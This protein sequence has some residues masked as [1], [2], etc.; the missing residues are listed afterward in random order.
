MAPIKGFNNLFT[1]D[2]RQRLASGTVAEQAA[3]QRLESVVSSASLGNGTTEF[4]DN[5]DTGEFYAMMPAPPETDSVAF[6]HYATDE[7][8]AATVNV[9]D[10]LAPAG[11]A[12]LETSLQT[13]TGE[14]FA[15][16]EAIATAL[17]TETLSAHRAAA[18]SRLAAADGIV[19][20]LQDRS[21]SPDAPL[22]DGV[23]E[24]DGAEPRVQ[25]MVPT[26]DGPGVY[27]DAPIS[28]FVTDEGLE[29]L[30]PT[31]AQPETTSGT[32]PVGGMLTEHFDQ[33]NH[34]A[35]DEYQAMG[36]VENLIVA[37]AFGQEVDWENSSHIHG[38]G[39][40]M[41]VRFAAG[42]DEAGEATFESLRVVDLV[43]ES[44]ATGLG[45]AEAGEDAQPDADT[46][47]VAIRQTAAEVGQSQDPER[48][49][50]AGIDELAGMY[51]QL[52]ETE[53]HRSA[54]TDTINA[55]AEP[56]EDLDPQTHRARYNQAF[57]ELESVDRAVVDLEG[58]IAADGA[59]IAAESGTDVTEVL[60]QARQQGLERLGFD[61]E[62]PADDS[63]LQRPEFLAVKDALA[64]DVSDAHGIGDGG[65]AGVEAQTA[66]LDAV[67][68]ASQT[69]AERFDVDPEVLERQVSARVSA[70]AAQPSDIEG[71]VEPSELFTPAFYNALDDS[72]SHGDAGDAY[73]DAVG[74]F[75][76]QVQTAAAGYG[77]TINDEHPPSFAEDPEPFGTH[78]R[79]SS[80]IVTEFWQQDGADGVLDS[81]EMLTPAGQAVLAAGL[82]VG[83]G[84]EFCPELIVRS[85]ELETEGWGAD[86]GNKVHIP[87]VDEIVAGTDAAAD[88][89]EGRWSAAATAAGEHGQGAAEQNLAHTGGRELD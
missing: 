73:G 4:V 54:V 44:T 78:Q 74:Q 15:P 21:V 19:S 56:A 59:R 6:I 2:F 18:G 71:T 80:Q 46:E 63:L 77:I 72:I 36:E 58:S 37:T 35:L 83:D 14:T 26:V 17:G 60:G 70:W 86:S 11:Q 64:A 13:G 75:Q 31:P 1:D 82:E 3:M 81:S 22:G 49:P 33:F 40:E 38:E 8:I 53:Q 85:V 23:I 9:N 48:G 20:S 39:P 89:S 61:G 47:P 66:T 10:L 16:R 84:G 43:D 88:Q 27:Q 28:D 62:L 65:S 45:I 67:S 76:D 34:A 12:L 24:A 41:T 29:V 5:T 57:S 79:G 69:A 42:V 50:A 7:P 25:W 52:G 32:G 87:S 55:L 51:V 30:T 68:A